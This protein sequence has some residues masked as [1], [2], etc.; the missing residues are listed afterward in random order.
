M[1]VEIKLP[2]TNGL[3]RSIQVD[4]STYAEGKIDLVREM[5]LEE[6]NVP[7]S[8][9]YPVVLST[10]NQATFLQFWNNPNSSIISY[11]ELPTVVELEEQ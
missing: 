1:N 5:K 6:T 11:S 10:V 4:L 9:V 8:V 2:P 3:G 7:L